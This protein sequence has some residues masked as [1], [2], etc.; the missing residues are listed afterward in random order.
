MIASLLDSQNC[1]GGNQKQAA[2]TVPP[3]F[4]SHL[5]DTDSI[6]S[7]EEEIPDIVKSEAQRLGLKSLH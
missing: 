6:F 2:G 5:N 7:L 1:L 4:K 3:Y